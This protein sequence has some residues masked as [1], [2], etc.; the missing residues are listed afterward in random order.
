MKVNLQSWSF[1][2]EKRGDDEGHRGGSSDNE[3]NDEKVYCQKEKYSLVEAR[4]Y[5][6]AMT[7][8]YPPMYIHF[9]LYWKFAH[10]QTNDKINMNIFISL[11]HSSAVHSLSKTY[12]KFL[13]LNQI[14][15]RTHL[16]ITSN[17]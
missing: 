17:S 10:A 1:H 5:F 7:L 8:Q 13:H 11:V 3:Y 2:K 16:A 6:G 14:T 15:P 9:S 12:I 4:N